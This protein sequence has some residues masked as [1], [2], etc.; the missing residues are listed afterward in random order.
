[1]GEF[2]AVVAVGEHRALAVFL[3]SIHGAVG[4]RRD[5]DAA[6]R[7]EGES[8]GPYE[9]NRDMTRD[10]L[11]A[12]LRVIRADETAPLEKDGQRFPALPLVDDVS[13]V[14]AEDEVTVFALG[15]PERSFGQREAI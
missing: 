2:L 7:I 4:H 11:R 5:D 1:A 8:V 15:D 3:E 14:L 9:E 10:R 12:D 13:G 6:L